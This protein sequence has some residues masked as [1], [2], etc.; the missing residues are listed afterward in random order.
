M[1]KIILVIIICLFSAINIFSQTLRWETD[2]EKSYQI[3][4]GQCTWEDIE[5]SN[6]YYIVKENSMGI[7]LNA[8][9][10]VELAKTLDSQRPT[11]YEIQAY[12]GAWDDESLWQLP[13]F[14]ACA[15]TMEAKYQQ[16]I[17]FYFIGCNREYDCGEFDEP[18]TLPYFKIY[19][20]SEDNQRT[21]IG[22]ILEKPE[23]SFED[24]VLKII[25]H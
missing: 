5:M 12:I 14:Y 6:F 3:P 8:D 20:I 18:K 22:E 2:E 23:I 19:Q 24:D 13:R 4:V 17:D 21:L 25:K 16:P 7:I 10:T 1:K 15:I 9:A 11:R